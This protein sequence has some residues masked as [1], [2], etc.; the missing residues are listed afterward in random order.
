MFFKI[1][2]AAAAVVG[3][4]AAACASGDVLDV[5][6]AFPTI[7]AA[8]DAA[9]DGDEIVLAAGVYESPGI[10]IDR[11]LSVTIRS[12]DPSD[13]VVVAAT[14]L[15]DADDMGLLVA[16]GDADQPVTLIAAGL[17]FRRVE[18]QNSEP[19]MV[20]AGASCTFAGCVFDGG[21]SPE[22]R[23]G[24]IDAMAGDGEHPA[25][26][27]LQGCELF[28]DVG[29]ISV[30]DTA[31]S[32]VDTTM[33][34]G[35]MSVL[36]VGESFGEAVPTVI[37]GCTFRAV[38]ASLGSVFDLRGGDGA[39]ADTIENC[40]FED[41]PTSAIQSLRNM[42]MEDVVV[43]RC[44]SAMT[45]ISFIEVDARLMSV[46][47]D[48]LTVRDCQLGSVQS[49]FLWF[50]NVRGG[51][52]ARDLLFE[53]NVG[54]TKW[55]Q[56]M[57]DEN[58][59]VLEDSVF[60][61][62]TSSQD[63]VECH[64]DGMVRRCLFEN[65]TITGDGPGVLTAWG[66]GGLGH[67]RD[68]EIIIEDC[69]FRGNTSSA[70]AFAIPTRVFPSGRPLIMRRCLFEGNSGSAGAVGVGFP[71]LANREIG[72]EWLVMQNCII[73]G[74]DGLF[75]GVNIGTVRF[76]S[77]T[78]V[79]NQSGAASL[80]VASTSMVD[81]VFVPHDSS[82]S[83]VVHPDILIPNALDDDEFADFEASNSIVPSSVQGATLSSLDPLFVR[84]P[85]DGGDGWGDDPDTPGI[86]ESLN[87]DFGDLR[88]RSGSPAIDSGSRGIM[89]FFETDFAGN[90]RLRDDPGV[91]DTGRNGMIDRGAH[92][93]QGVTC[94]ADVNQN[95]ALTPND[96]NAWVLAFNA[97]S[98]LA[99]QNR[100]GR[101][102]PNDFNAWILNFNAGCP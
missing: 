22:L 79:G 19:L 100:D 81:S 78:I 39:V 92:E 33:H 6:S 47:I 99:D 82:A 26:L 32:L 63:T 102:S 73:T 13:A 23:G 98:P 77:C 51:L 76:E 67:I 48:G 8:I 2:H 43:E 94:L 12:A 28:G 31:L 14:V 10:V 93:F 34:D 25:V 85:S 29:V 90:A 69:V 84:H 72:Y 21:M 64:A 3:V 57:T 58:G 60:R 17:T 75:A 96:F 83:I 95:G 9:D 65:N 71:N 18:T 4:F 30:S 1:G 54:A 35:R 24:M 86:D 11:A 52:V 7:Q 38:T 87:D 36:N 44:G 89:R 50:V 80:G 20:I 16:Q 66:Q 101:L 70:G 59:Y 97:G 61:N 40:R 74:N 41:V 62:N 5:P 53:D 45:A 55:L 91:P 15:T 49:D 68:E 88:L 42:A 37:S 46:S 27:A 56:G